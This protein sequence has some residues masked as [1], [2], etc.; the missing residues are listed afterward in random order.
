ME[1]LI[2]LLSVERQPT[3]VVLTRTCMAV[4]FIHFVSNKMFAIFFRNRLRTN[5]V[6]GRGPYSEKQRSI[7]SRYI[8]ML[9]NCPLWTTE[10]S[11]VVNTHIP[12]PA[13]DHQP[14]KQGTNTCLLHRYI[15][16]TQANPRWHTW[17]KLHS[18]YYL[19]LFFP[20]VSSFASSANMQ[21][22]KTKTDVNFLGRM[23]TSLCSVAVKDSGRM[24]D[25]LNLHS[26]AQS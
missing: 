22:Q 23:K 6:N 10:E 17:R 20:C 21:I 3:T 15:T 13:N 1:E 4:F 25:R 2:R 26:L 9:V 18:S 16:P 19:S 14:T 24:A 8:L 5:A 7:P 11:K 12:L